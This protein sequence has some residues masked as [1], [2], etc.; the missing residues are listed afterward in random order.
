MKNERKRVTTRLVAGLLAV[1]VAGAG[2]ALTSSPAT[3]TQNVWTA[4]T[5]GIDL[6]ATSAL[7]AVKSHSAGSNA[8]VLVSGADANWPDGL[9]ASALAGSVSGPVILT[10]PD[11]LQGSTANAIATVDTALSGAA[12]I[13]LVGG[14]AAISAN[15]ATQLTDLGYTVS[16]HSGDDRVATAVA[17]AEYIETLGTI[18][19]YDGGKAVMLATGDNFPD[20]LAAGALAYGQNIPILLVRGGALSAGTTAFLDSETTAI[21]QVIVLGGTSAVSA[22]VATAVAAISNGA[23]ALEVTRVSGATRYDTAVEIAKVMKKSTELDGF[24]LSITGV[25]LVDGATSG[26]ALTASAMAGNGTS[27]EPASNPYYSARGADTQIILLTEGGSD[28]LNASTETYIASLASTIGYIRAVGGTSSISAAALTAADAATTQVTPTVAITAN[29]SAATV[30]FTYSEKMNSTA[31]GLKTDYTVNNA[32]VVGA[33]YAVSVNAAKTV[34]TLSLGQTVSGTNNTL[35]V[36]DVVCVAAN[37]NYA[38]TANTASTCAT[39]GNDA[40]G[41]TA[42]AGKALIGST[43][44]YVTLDSALASGTFTTGDLSSNKSNT[45]SSVTKNAYSNTWAIVVGSTIVAGETITLTK[46][47]ITDVAGNAG[48]STYVITAS[49]DSTKPTLKSAVTSATSVI[50]ATATMTGGTGDYKVVGNTGGIASGVLFEAWS[51][52]GLTGTTALSVAVNSTDKTIIVVT[53]LTA[54]YTKSA[55]AIVSHLNADATFSANFTAAVTTVGSVDALT[56]ATT[57]DGGQTTLTVSLAMS[58]A[59]APS[60]WASN[61]TPGVSLD[62]NAD[63]TVDSVTTDVCGS[64]NW[65][66]GTAAC[67]VVVTSAGESLTIGTSKV[68]VSN[69]ATDL[70]GNAGTVTY[71]VLL[72]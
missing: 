57:P 1:L 20:A 13:H 27:A 48:A 19:S 34:A 11:S 5:S 71:K 32:A 64:F 7:A 35:S 44:A 3:A 58:E 8:I 28:T 49:S 62:A 15:V 55:S 51:V 24:A 59:M 56:A 38:G 68:V 39:V 63:G 52:E 69:T 26:N 42:T 41:P 17:V 16:R 70:K 23:V 37:A 72:S 54:G 4:R 31:I 30:T 10:D 46:T 50:A 29:E 61:G 60:L 14:T 22:D 33:G 2:L 12:T 66:A 21:A 47:G 45:F 53:P 40:T 6:Y 18:G 65:E 67:T 43:N 25:I 36:S 9:S